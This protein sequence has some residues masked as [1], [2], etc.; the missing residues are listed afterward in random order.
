MLRV[1]HGGALIV[2]LS[3]IVA[4]FS[5]FTAFG[6]G[7]NADH[8]S[9]ADD[10]TVRIAAR[11]LESGGVQVA[12]Q[13]RDSAGEWGARHTPAASVLPADAPVG[14]WRHSSELSVA[15]FWPILSVS[16][17]STEGLFGELRVAGTRGEGLACIIGHGDPE[18]DFWELAAGAMLG[19][20]Y[21]TRVG[22]RV[23][24]HVDGSEQ[25]AAIRECVE[26][27]AFAVAA[28]LANFDAVSEALLEAGEAGVE[29][30]TYNSGADRANEVNSILHVSID[31]RGDGRLA[32]ERMNAAGLTGEVVCLIHEEINVGLEER[33]EG[34]EASYQ[35]TVT[36]MQVH[37]EAGLAA[38]A[39]ELANPEI[40]GAI[41]LNSNTGS[42]LV[43]AA[44]AAGRDDLFIATFGIDS[45]SLLGLLQGR[46]QFAIWDMPVLQGMFIANALRARHFTQAPPI[47][48]L[49]GAKVSIEPVLFDAQRL[50]RALQ[51]LPRQALLALIEAAG[52]GPEQ[53][54]RMQQLLDG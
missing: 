34:L 5:A 31:E 2:L 52:L 40:V 10:A 28:T 46:V 15:A 48:Q 23:E 36:R 18:Q 11:H 47:L 30:Y 35:G 13:E 19:H 42:W 44:A 38:A 22:T 7:A 27:G 32:G 1:K 37:D 49:G 26:D 4:G 20:S 39:E 3:V 21:L 9:Q 14:D 8:G 17:Y 6:P 51:T 25:A 29:V 43:G 53:L 16:D 24:L 50:V 33:C 45:T 54:E 12:L 41:G